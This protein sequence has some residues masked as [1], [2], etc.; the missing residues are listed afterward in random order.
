MSDQS[1]K[2]PSLPYES[3][4][5]VRSDAIDSL[6]VVVEEFRHKKTGA[7]HYHINSENDENVFLVAFRTVPMD[8]TG[9]AH[10]LE[11]TALCGSEKFPVRD[12]FFMMTRR[13]LNTFMNAFTS[14]DW[15]AYPFASKNEKDF[16]N[17][18][19]VYLDAV[20][21]ARLGE[22][23]FAQEGHRIEFSQ[24][25]DS[26]SKLEHKGVVYNEM[27]GAMSSTN[28]LLWQSMTKY[29]FP[30]T[31]YH[32]N[33]GGD[34]EHIKDLTYEGLKSFYETHYHPSNAIFMT[35][36]NQPVAIL[37]EKFEQQALHRFPEPLTESIRVDSEKRYFSPLSVEE[38]YP[39]AA[40]DDVNGKTHIVMGWLLGN[41][42]DLYEQLKAQLV[43][44]LLLENSAAPLRHVLETTEMGSAP[45]PMCGLEDSNFEMSFLC[46]LEG[47]SPE[48]AAAFESVVLETLERLV[49]TGISHEL[50]E[51]SLHQLELHQREIG[52][53]GYP[54]GLQ[55]I[56]MGL[57]AACHGGDPVAVLNLDPALEKLRQ[58]VQDPKFIPQLIQQYFIDNPHRVRLVMK[59]DS[60]LA[61]KRELHEE[62]KLQALKEQLSEEKKQ[63]IIDLAKRLEERQ[64]LVEDDSILP[65]VSLS[66]VPENFY[67]AAHRMSQ[68]HN[69]DV[70][71]Y[72][73]GTNG[74]S[75]LQY[76][77]KLPELSTEQLDYLS[78]FTACLTEVGL[79]SD[80]YLSTQER[81]TKVCG[82]ISAYTT[83]KGEIDNE[84]VSKGYFVLSSKSLTNNFSDMQTLMLDTL[85][86]AKFGEAQRLKDL[87]SQI[88]ARR[89]SSIVSSGHVYA[90]NAAASGLSPIAA[91]S[92]RVSGLQG[93]TFIRQLEK[94]LE[95]PEGAQHLTGMLDQIREAL[96][97]PDYS[98]VLIAEPNK[99]KSL[100]QQ[101]DFS[102][103]QGL[104]VDT[105]AFNLPATRQ[106]TQQIWLT[107]SAVSF[108]AAAYPTVTISHPDAPALTILG[109]FLRNGFL[110]RAI[111]E[112]GGAYGAGASQ[113]SDT[114]VF[115][116][117]SYRDPRLSGTF[118][119]FKQSIDW[120]LKTEHS[121][122]ALE[123][124]I[125]GV[126]SSID[127]PGSPAGEAKSAFHSLLFGRTPEQRQRF[128]KDIL[129]VGIDDLK[130]VTQQYLADKDYSVAV[131]TGHEKQAEAEAYCQGAEVFRL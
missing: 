90:M 32:Y 78:I 128:R 47:S 101:V 7:I 40:T 28:S 48:H 27:K 29:L 39:A 15:T 72:D 33:S 18:L 75:Y 124:A 122:Q 51:A 81:Q 74:L 23:D 62:L 9:V 8:S 97:K 22:L 110:H 46:G 44:N 49:D 123:E 102:R 120:M 109:N 80:D 5:W 113:N 103:L 61:S 84:Q 57:S 12:P 36:G 56:L 60:E 95:T 100:L 38:S 117:Y 89:E 65:K 2:S 99:T 45:S 126:V 10:V 67:I 73:Q 121:P 55:L 71:V 131:L 91:L 85:D 16:Y 96:I 94:D 93:V 52:G 125:L 17:L 64:S 14:S 34:P 83:I 42:A 98:L 53:D 35:F 25:D 58:D 4:E 31:T 50:I 127:K 70:F 106:H 68:V 107:E 87:V 92:H 21:F 119:D 79:G 69:N 105:Q 59:P 66:D 26:S 24:A 88:R 6:N 13:S 115:R 114:A 63:E 43:C 108:C 41:S 82:G 1:K 76:I 111:R 129:K 112:Q 130:R 118:D 20:F 37:Q 30:S 19:D 86:Q 54:Y 104:E 77:T 11:H 116:F 3:F